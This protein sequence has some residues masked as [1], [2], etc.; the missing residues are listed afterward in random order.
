MDEPTLDDDLLRALRNTPDRNLD[1]L[2]EAVGLPR[3]NFG[4][5]PRSRIRDRVRSLVEEGLVEEHGKRYRISEH[6]RRL[7][8]D[9][10]L[11]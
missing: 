4:R 3:T 8:A 10:A 2:A 7:L 1:Q 5:A 6:G 11:E 9:R